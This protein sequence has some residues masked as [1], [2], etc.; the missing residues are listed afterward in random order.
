[1]YEYGPSN[2]PEENQFIFLI[3]LFNYE[4][5]TSV[6]SYFARKSKIDIL[7]AKQPL[8]KIKIKRNQRNTHSWATRLCI[9]NWKERK[10]IFTGTKTEIK[11]TLKKIF[12][13]FKFKI[14]GLWFHISS[15]DLIFLLRCI[16]SKSHDQVMSLH[17]SP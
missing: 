1:M 5:D 9:Q 7:L 11:I 13:S 17:F 4:K 8:G 12:L 3:W 2:L 10:K 6:L 15:I 16:K 14:R